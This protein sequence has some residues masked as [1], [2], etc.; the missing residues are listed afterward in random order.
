MTHI[1]VDKLI[2][3]GSDNGLSPGRCQ[4]IIWT[5]AGILLVGP[6]GTNFNEIVIK[7]Q[8]FSLKTICLKMLSAKCQTFCLGLNVLKWWVGAVANDHVQYAGGQTVTSKFEIWALSDIGYLSDMHHEVAF[9]H[10]LFCVCAIILQLCTEHGSIT[11]VFCA[12]Y[13]NDWVTGQ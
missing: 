6:L 12:K 10:N 9:V 7:I 2:I 3:I 1:C 8:T 5:S 4:A 11:A 13:Q